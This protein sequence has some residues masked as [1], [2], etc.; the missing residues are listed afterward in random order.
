MEIKVLTHQG[1]VVKDETDFIQVVSE[2]HNFG[3]LNNHIPL[4]TVIN[5]GYIKYSLENEEK[6]VSL[7]AAIFEFSNNVATVLAQE[8][9][10]GLNIEDAKTKMNEF[11][12]QRIE[13]NRK[14]TADFSKKEKELRDH[15]K[16]A[17]AG[18]L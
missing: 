9:Q 12:N 15:I 11:R 17:G 1:L 14:E 4:V 5:D 3:I 8:A 18:N 6:Y 13:M 16:N 7:C 2:N 10:I